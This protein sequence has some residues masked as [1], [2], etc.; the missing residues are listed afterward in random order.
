MDDF[1][2]RMTKKHNSLLK[3][4]RL[5]EKKLKRK[6]RLRFKKKT[7]FVFKIFLIYILS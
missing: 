4:N 1:R 5:V 2:P 3:E 7:N 6:G